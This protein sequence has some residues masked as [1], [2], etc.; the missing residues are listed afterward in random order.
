[1]YFHCRNSYNFTWKISTEYIYVYIDKK[2][3][4]GISKTKKEKYPK[5]KKISLIESGKHQ[6]IRN[7]WNVLPVSVANIKDQ[8]MATLQQFLKLNIHLHNTSIEIRA[9]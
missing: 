8:W 1:M 7:P 9:P 5:Q 4:I 2:Q 6:I 3:R